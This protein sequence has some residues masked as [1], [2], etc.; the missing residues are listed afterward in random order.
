VKAV[1]STTGCALTS[2]TVCDRTL[3]YTGKLVGALPLWSCLFHAI[4]G[5]ESEQSAAFLGSSD[6]NAFI[7]DPTV[8]I[9]H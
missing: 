8:E 7:F 2:S 4:T 3:I 5:D 1:N 9:R 6:S